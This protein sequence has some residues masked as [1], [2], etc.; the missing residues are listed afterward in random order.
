MVYGFISKTM[1]NT[2]VMN[3]LEIIILNIGDIWHKMSGLNLTE[4]GII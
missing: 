2:Q 1:E 4:I 3:G